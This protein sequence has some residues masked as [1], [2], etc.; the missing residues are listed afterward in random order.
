M[1]D[2]TGKR[3]G[4]LTVKQSDGIIEYKCGT[5]KEKWLCKCDCGREVSVLSSDLKT[6]HTKSCGCLQKEDIA[7]RSVTHGKS[8]TRLYSIWNGIKNR[9]YNQNQRSYQHYGARG[10]TMCPEWK[11]NF[12]TFY[13]WAMCNGY[14][15]GLS[16]DRIDVNKGYFPGNCR[17][18]NSF[19]QALNRTD[20]RF[21]TYNKKT[22]TLK[23][24]A[25]EVGL[26]Y[27]CLLWRI[28]NGWDIG[29]ALYTP[30]R[31]SKT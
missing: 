4:R 8:K 17:F 6:G 31:R 10:I 21:I 26:A 2:L 20:N 25:D 27:S 7:K 11:D 18:A 1:E 15:E 16:I 14:K 29:K 23:E 24:W 12:D 3:F 13:I 5:K 9:C 19:A 28:D 30:S 22:Q